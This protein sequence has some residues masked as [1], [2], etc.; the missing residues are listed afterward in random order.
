M[1]IEIPKTIQKKY[2][3]LIKALKYKFP[4]MSINEDL[5]FAENF[6]IFQKKLT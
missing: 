1:S 6:N 3:Q 5:K 4:K 2:L